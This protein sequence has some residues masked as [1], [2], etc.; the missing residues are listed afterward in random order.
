MNDLLAVRDGQIAW[1]NERLDAKT[2]QPKPTATYP[3]VPSQGGMLDGIWTEFNFHRSG[4]AFSSRRVSANILAWSEKLVVSPKT[5]TSAEQGAVLWTSPLPATQQ[6]D[7]IVLASNMAVLA[8]RTSGPDGQRT[9][10]LAMVSAVD[11]R[12]LDEISLAA[13]PVFDGMAIA[14]ER[15]VVVLQDGSLVCYGKKDH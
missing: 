12:I 6:V 7:A 4:Q 13:L 15:L 11:G 5:A 1:H 3:A 14:Y 8:G 9:G 2:G 10:F